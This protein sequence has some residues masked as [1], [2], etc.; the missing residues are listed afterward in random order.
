M[1]PRVTKQFFMSQFPSVNH[2]KPEW[3]RIYCKQETAKTSITES[4]RMS[5]IPRENERKSPTNQDSEI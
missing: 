2:G 4:T 3:P 1:P 5:I